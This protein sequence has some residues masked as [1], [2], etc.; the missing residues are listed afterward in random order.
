MTCLGITGHRNLGRAT[1]DLIAAELRGLFGSLAL[2]EGESLTGVTCLAEG[3]D[4]LF[5]QLVLDYGGALEAII[6]AADYRD[7]LHISYQAVYDGFLFRAR[8][9]HRLDHIRSDPESY[10]AASRLMLSTIDELIAVWDG[11]PAVG[12]GGTADV[13]AEARSLDIPVRVVWPEG[14]VRG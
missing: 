6:P 3:A 2:A 10:M 11:L 4:A 13:V 14:S 9:V 8:K 5:A 1:T 12:Y 7:R